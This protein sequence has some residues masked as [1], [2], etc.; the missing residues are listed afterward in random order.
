MT[1]SRLKSRPFVK[2]KR[3]VKHDR[4]DQPSPRAKVPQHR[5]P[6]RFRSLHPNRMRVVVDTHI[7]VS[8]LL[9]SAGPPAQVLAAI[10]GQRLRPVVCT[11][12]LAEYREVLKRPRLKLRREDAVELLR[13]VELTADWVS[14]PPDP[15]TLLLPDRGDWPFLASAHVADCPLIT[16]NLKDFPALLGVRVMSAREWLEGR[17]A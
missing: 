2:P 3:L 1:R 9:S 13:L 4:P 7:L 10:V 17:A 15:G 11:A 8:G 14:V 12:I 5:R 6:S 16:G